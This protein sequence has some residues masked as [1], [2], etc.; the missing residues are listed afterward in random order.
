LTGGDRE[1]EVQ[2]DRLARYLVAFASD[3]LIY[4]NGLPNMSIDYA[5]AAR[6]D[7]LRNRAESILCAA[8]G[9]P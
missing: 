2:R 6:G 4:L 1:A 7:V 3:V 8:R 5:S 9:Q